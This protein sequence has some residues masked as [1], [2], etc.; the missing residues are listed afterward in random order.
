MEVKI[1]MFALKEKNG[2][3]YV[4]S[5]HAKQPG[6]GC[7]DLTHNPNHAI[8]FSRYEAASAVLGL[9]ERTGCLDASAFNLPPWELCVSVVDIGGKIPY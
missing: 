1:K 9:M 3:G 8:C 2:P 7:F 6:G 4:S 5:L